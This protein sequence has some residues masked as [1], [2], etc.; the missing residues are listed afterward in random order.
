[1]VKYIPEVVLLTPRYSLSSL[2]ELDIQMNRLNLV[3]PNSDNFRIN[4]EQHP[5]E[6]A[7]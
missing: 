4:D 7:V 2:S 3:E 5:A 6:S 1:M